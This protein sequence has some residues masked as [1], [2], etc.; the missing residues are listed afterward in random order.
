[1]YLGKLVEVGSA[2]DIYESAAHPYTRALIDT[3]PE[4]DPQLARS[5]RGR[6]ITGELPSAMLPPSGCRFR[7]RC[8]FAQD[9]CALEEPPL[10]PF[11]PR[12]LAACH[13]PLQT[14]TGDA[15][16]D[17]PATTVVG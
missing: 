17:A 13:F 9:I 8:P 12:H 7:T 4:P 2:I 15:T 10:R 14:P 5:A 6:H 16:A 3:I 11:G 1:M